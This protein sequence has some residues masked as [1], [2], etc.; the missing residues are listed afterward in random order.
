MFLKKLF[1]LTFQIRIVS[2]VLEYEAIYF[3]LLSKDK[4][5]IGPSCPFKI[6][7]FFVSIRS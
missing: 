5:D 2:S 3:P 1:W 7:N 4:Q 6:Y